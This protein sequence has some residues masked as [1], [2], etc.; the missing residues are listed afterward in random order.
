MYE[1]QDQLISFVID[2]YP[3]I[4]YRSTET[5]LRYQHLF[6]PN[7]TTDI[8]TTLCQLDTIFKVGTISMGK[9]TKIYIVYTT[10]IVIALLSLRFVNKSYHS[11]SWIHF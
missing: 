2:A 9:P 4:S 1:T 5:A 7:Y 6:L 8:P 11:R 10:L 3:L